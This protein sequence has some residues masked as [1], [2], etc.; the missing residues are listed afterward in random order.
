MNIINIY[1]GTTVLSANL[2]NGVDMDSFSLTTN[3]DETFD[4]GTF[5]IVSNENNAK[6]LTSRDYITIV[7][8]ENYGEQ[9][10]AIVHQEQYIVDVVGETTIKK[11]GGS[12]L[13]E[14]QVS[15]YEKSAEMQ[16]V[17]TQNL[18]TT[19]PLP[20]LWEEGTSV[21]NQPQEVF[22]GLKT[23]IGASYYSSNQIIRWG[24]N[25]DKNHIEYLPKNYVENASTHKAIFTFPTTIQRS[26]IT[27][28]MFTWENAYYFELSNSS[29][30]I[31][32]SGEYP[33]KTSYEFQ[34]I[35]DNQTYTMKIYIANPSGSLHSKEYLFAYGWQFNVLQASQNVRDISSKYHTT[36]EVLQK[37]V[38]T[39]KPYKNLNNTKYTIGTSCDY[40]QNVM[41][42]DLF[43]TGNNLFENLLIVGRTCNSIPYLDD[44]NNVQMLN[45]GVHDD[46]PSGLVDTYNGYTRIT[47]YDGKV[48]ACISDLQ[49]MI[50]SNTLGNGTC[51]DSWRTLEVENAQQYTADSCYYKS[52][53]PMYSLKKMEVKIWDTNGNY[54]GVYDITKYMY[55]SSVYGCLN[56][57][58]QTLTSIQSALCWEQYG[59]KITGF[60]AQVSSV[61]SLQTPPIAIMHILHLV[62]PDESET[63]T[64]LSNWHTRTMY[65]ATYVP[66]INA[67]VKQYR[68]D[69][70]SINGDEIIINQQTNLGSLE[71]TG[72]S[73][74]NSLLMLGNDTITQKKFVSSWSDVPEINQQVTINNEK[75]IITQVVRS[76]SNKGYDLGITYSKNFNRLSANQSLATEKRWA[77]VPLNSAINRTIHLDDYL[78]LSTSSSGI[79]T[80][81]ETDV[82]YVDKRNAVAPESMLK[83]MFGGTGADRKRF[84]EFRFFLSSDTKDIQGTD[85]YTTYPN[86]RTCSAF[87]P[88]ES[89]ANNYWITLPIVTG[90]FGNSVFLKASTKDNY[91][92]KVGIISSN[93]YKFCQD[94]A[95]SSELGEGQNLNFIFRRDATDT[96]VWNTNNTIIATNDKGDWVADAQDCVQC[97][98]NIADSVYIEKDA[99]E[100]LDVV[101]QMHFVSNN[102]DLFIGR[103]FSELNPM[104]CDLDMNNVTYT[105][106]ILK[107][108]YDASHTSIDVADVVTTFTPVIDFGYSNPTNSVKT[109]NSIPITPEEYSTDD[110]YI[111]VALKYSVL[112]VGGIIDKYELLVARN[113]HQSR[114]FENQVIC[115]ATLR[116]DLPH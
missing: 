90:A 48:G 32:D 56:T 6:Q 100:Q 25:T 70:M 43:L 110:M 96:N 37:L 97:W 103:A 17:L 82:F 59:N 77:D 4:V 3:L 71:T 102:K 38:K 58:D 16:N 85:V 105:G 40:L 57:A 18:A 74:K 53:F 41:C 8:Y 62:E 46:A 22:A 29:S 60:Q 66:V 99:R 86:G 95:Y 44:N 114:W 14:Y 113:L 68:P 54:R 27:T 111:G 50:P 39:I 42:P 36:H 88:N 80:T 79:P 73:M 78:I 94:V 72:D 2:I 98:G 51:T 19:Q 61:I 30:T 52:D 45:L 65:R 11:V 84:K 35:N 12:L 75:W 81:N 89:Q 5:N 76:F 91:S 115:Y 49:N 112:S 23:Y 15:F 108:N 93:G 34:N 7:E 9:T 10:Q 31:I 69:A 13:Y 1:K 63:G 26:G 83:Y 116:S 106:V 20:S 101:Y 87:I 33:T 107:G 104:I 55:E 109:P 64:G 47:N 24:D 92:A 28:A 21:D 67:R